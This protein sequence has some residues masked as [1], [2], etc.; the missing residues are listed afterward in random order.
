MVDPS[1]LKKLQ[2]LLKKEGKVLSADEIE[3]ISEKLKEE[4]L[5]NFAIG[6]KHI[7]ERHFT[8]AI[9][10]FQLSDCKDAP[11]II[12]LLSLKVGD[13]FLFEEYINEK[14]EKDCLEKLEIDIFCKLSDREIIL[15]KDNLHKITDLLR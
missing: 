8:E 5:K 1:K 3:N 12:A 11:L 6:L 14:S 13:T 7:T 9:K 4:N 15:T 2:I 10:W